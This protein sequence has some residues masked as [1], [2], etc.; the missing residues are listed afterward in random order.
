MEKRSQSE[1]ILSTHA[2]IIRTFPFH[3]FVAVAF[4]IVVV[5]RTDGPVVVDV[6]RRTHACGGAGFGV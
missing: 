2:Q 3:V 5:I 4:E 1:F 6:N